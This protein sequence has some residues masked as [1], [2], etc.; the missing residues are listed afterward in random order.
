MKL[1]THAVVYIANIMMMN[2][3]RWT[4]TIA[5]WKPTSGAWTV[6]WRRASEQPAYGVKRLQDIRPE[7]GT[8]NPVTYSFAMEIIL[9][10]N[11]YSTAYTLWTLRRGKHQPI[12]FY[13]KKVNAFDAEGSKT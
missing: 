13:L 10:T 4:P 7:D 11:A 12:N 6:K 9:T 3:F 1:N 5:S 2:V 8:T